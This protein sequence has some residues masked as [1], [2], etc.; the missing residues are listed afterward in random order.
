MSHYRALLS[1][2]IEANSDAAAV[3]AANEQATAL[4]HP[5]GSVVGHV[6][7]VGEVG[8]DL[9]IVRVVSS[10]P[11]LLRQLPPDWKP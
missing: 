10:D 1:I 5:G 8:E 11:G 7:L 6:E 3:E 9:E 2:P 4:Q